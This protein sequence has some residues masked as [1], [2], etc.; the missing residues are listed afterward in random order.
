MPK[1]PRATKSPARRGLKL[2]VAKRSAIVK[3]IV[4]THKVTMAARYIAC[5][6]Q[7]DRF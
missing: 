3:M 7:S 5:D 1:Q 2:G 6:I 4:R